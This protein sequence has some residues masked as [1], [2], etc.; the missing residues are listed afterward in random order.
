[1][2]FLQDWKTNVCLKFMLFKNVV[3][4]LVNPKKAKERREKEIRGERREKE[5]ERHRRWR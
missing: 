1:M 5:S 3:N 4:I 2:R